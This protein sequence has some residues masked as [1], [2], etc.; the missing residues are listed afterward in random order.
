M[1][2]PEPNSNKRL[3]YHSTP[4]GTTYTVNLRTTPS[5]LLIL[6]LG[7][8]AGC[9]SNPAK[10]SS[11]TV[12]KSSRLYQKL[13]QTP[14][15]KHLP[16]PLQGVSR[17]QLV[18]TWGNARSLGRSHEGIDILAKRGTPVLSATDGFISKITSYGAG[19]NAITIVGYALS[20]Q[21]YA[22]LDRFG[23]YKVGDPV[24]V[25]DV[26]GYVGSTGNASTTHLHYGIYLSPNR[27]ATNPYSYLR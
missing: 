13:E 15:P 6:M 25:G 4:H 19:G 21:Y 27:V 16:M 2:R 20:Q 26:L 10:K 22:H 17:R 12:S 18:D 8:L 7:L 9:A 24:K 11:S 1:T 23:A 3:Q 14:L 5:Y